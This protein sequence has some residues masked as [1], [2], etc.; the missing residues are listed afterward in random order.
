MIACGCSAGS[1]RTREL[2]TPEGEK[3]GYVPWDRMS[4]RPRRDVVLHHDGSLSWTV[5]AGDDGKP[6][7]RITVGPPR[8]DCEPVFPEQAEWLRQRRDRRPGGQNVG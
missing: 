8:G 6:E 4:S 7:W 2:L 5:D 1:P 3:N